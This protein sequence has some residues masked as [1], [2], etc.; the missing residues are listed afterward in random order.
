MPPFYNNTLLQYRVSLPNHPSDNEHDQPRQQQVVL[1]LLNYDFGEM[2]ACDG[3]SARWSRR[4][5]LLVGLIL[6]RN[7]RT[8]D[9]SELY[10]RLGKYSSVW[11]VV[12]GSGNV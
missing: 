2:I 4:S 5:T 7:L 6:K 9:V 3:P 11:K 1:L 10:Y 12:G 8:V